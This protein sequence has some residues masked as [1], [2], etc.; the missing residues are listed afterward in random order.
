[1]KT[2]MRCEGDEAGRCRRAPPDLAENVFHIA[3]A[4]AASPSPWTSTSSFRAWCV[5]AK[6]DKPRRCLCSFVCR[7]GSP[8]HQ[9]ELLPVPSH[10]QQAHRARFFPRPGFWCLQ[11]VNPHSLSQGRTP[12]AGTLLLRELLG[13]LKLASAGKHREWEERERG[14]EREH[15]PCVPFGNPARGLRPARRGNLIREMKGV[16]DGAFMARSMRNRALMVMWSRK[17]KGALV[18]Q[19]KSTGRLTSQRRSQQHRLMLVKQCSEYCRS[20]T[21]QASG[22][23]RSVFSST[24]FGA[25]PRVL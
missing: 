18:S 25:M 11:E 10:P 3:G 17:T 1:M 4:R 21:A 15:L 7:R 5:L 13:G 14:R 2:A 19:G 8:A 20:H 22:N 6:S 24:A 12:G 9:G 16:H 23:L